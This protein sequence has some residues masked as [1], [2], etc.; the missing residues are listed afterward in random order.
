MIC[1][2][3]TAK[4]LTHGSLRDRGEG[5]GDPAEASSWDGNE[6]DWDAKRLFSET[7]YRILR[8]VT[9]RNT[10]QL[11]GTRAVFPYHPE[12]GQTRHHAHNF[13]S[14]YPVQGD[15]RSHLVFQEDVDLTLRRP[16]V[17]IVRRAYP[18]IAPVTDLGAAVFSGWKVLNYIV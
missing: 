3:L 16:G 13:H 11:A 14:E 9:E 10:S 5:Q 12:S 1:Q 6:T 15:D 7:D 8:R 18:S 2:M 4:N 17:E